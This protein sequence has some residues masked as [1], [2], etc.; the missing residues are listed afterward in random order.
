MGKE[1]N[2][3]IIHADQH[4]RDCIGCYG[5]PQVKTPNIDALASD[6]VIYTQHYATFPVCTPSRYSLLCGQYPHQHLGWGNH[7]TLLP[8][9]ATFPKVMKAAGWHTDAVGKMH[10]TPTYLD[11]G[12]ERMVLAEQDGDGRFDDD[13]HTYLMEKGL[14][15]RTDIIDQRREYRAKASQEYWDNHGAVASNLSAE[16]YSTGYI[17]REALKAL[18]GWDVSRPNLLMVGY[19]K[20]HHPDDPPKEYADRYDPD[21]LELLPGYIEQISE[22][23]Y[24]RHK[25]YHDHRLL[26][27]ERLKKVMAYYYANIT[28]IDDGVGQ[29][30]S[31]LKAKGLFDNTIV[32]Y[33]SD[34][35]DYL[36]YHHMWGKG[37]YMYD[38][39]IGIPL[40]IRNPYN[41]KK[42]HN[43]GLSSNVNFAPT[44]LRLCGLDVPK[45]MRDK[46]ITTSEGDQFVIAEHKYK[47]VQFEY[48]VRSREYKLL[49]C[50]DWQNRRFYD[51]VN[52][53]YELN[54]LADDPAY[55]QQILTHEQYLIKEILFDNHSVEY[56][57]DYA[58][59]VNHKTYEETMQRREKVA[60]YYKQ[61]LDD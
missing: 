48:M 10:F 3:I 54:N 43:D 13:Y 33:T 5:N 20:P 41:N 19:V 35:G 38:P 37:G 18:D 6:G 34:H 25:G 17:T 21:L 9:L 12:F 28:M 14:I 2:V 11:V 56:R 49:L 40:I 53:P 1:P 24:D 4:R 50:S 60:K 52:D 42:G 46:N 7:C 8:G 57:D 31:A 22:D 61:K 32:I 16:D 51:L 23:D 45:G 39:V 26:S 58:P 30:V 44:L 27:P 59:V 36:G 55:A 47:G 15:D 29:I